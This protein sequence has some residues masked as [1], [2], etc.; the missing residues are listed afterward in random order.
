MI[1]NNHKIT[2]NQSNQKVIAGLL[3][4]DNNIE[5]Y[6]I[7]EDNIRK[8]YFIKN[9]KS[10]PFSC[11]PECFK[12][13]LRIKY[14]SDLQAQLYL[15]NYSVEYQLELYTYY[16]YG[17]I[18]NNPDFLDGKLQEVENFREQSDCISLSWAT[19]KIT[20]D[21]NVLEIREIKIIDFIN[22]N[23]P[24]KLIAQN[25]SI[26]QNYLDFLKRKLFDKCSVN[27]KVALVIKAKEQG[28]I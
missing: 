16:L 6:G 1:T 7:M 9:G 26:T 5:L 17:A 18:D 28:V 8:V 2:K 19:K 22:N 27:T 10:L 15:A 12:K 11:L 23:Q 25:L 14:Q 21:G 13:Q 3:P 24:D 4:T 20:I